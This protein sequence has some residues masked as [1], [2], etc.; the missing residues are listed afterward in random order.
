M[1][2][3][4]FAMTTPQFIDG[5]KDVTRRFGWWNLK[6][7]DRLMAVEKAMGLKKGEKVKKLGVIEIVSVTQERIDAMTTDLDYGFD[8]LRREGFPFGAEF[9]SVFVDILCGHSQKLPSDLVNRIE[10]RKVDS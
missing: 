2:M 8:E 9:P 3:I 4:S 7:G 10:F 1:R 5:S 6:A